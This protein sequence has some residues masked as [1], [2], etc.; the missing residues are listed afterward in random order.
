M[1]SQVRTWI[2]RM[3][4]LGAWEMSTSV[5][6][7]LLNIMGSQWGSDYKSASHIV[8]AIS[9]VLGGC[10]DGDVI[11]STLKFSE[12]QK[13]CWISVSMVLPRMVFF[14][15]VRTLCCQEPPDKHSFKT[16]QS[17]IVLGTHVLSLPFACR[18]ILARNKFNQKGEKA[19]KKE[20]IPRR[21]NNNSFIVK[22]G[23][24]CVSTQLLRDANSLQPHGL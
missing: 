17:P 12:K 18:K 11:Y 2:C 8:S 14:L 6:G 5:M 1:G 22:D 21:L 15:L 16:E 20:N 4:T 19:G 23:C 3:V 9:C 13:Q 7:F 10:E 24:M